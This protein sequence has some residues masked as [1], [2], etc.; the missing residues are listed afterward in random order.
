M[1]QRRPLTTALAIAGVSA[2]V[3]GCSA[4]TALLTSPAPGSVLARQ[5]F[6]S[7]PF[8][9]T[10]LAS[11]AV[12]T[13]PGGDPAKPLLLPP[14]YDQVVIASEPDYADTPD[15]NTQNE[16]GPRAGRYLYRPHEARANATVSVTDLETGIT[17]TIAQRADWEAL[18]PSV[19][20]PWGTLLVAE[21]TNAASHRSVGRG[22]LSWAFP[23]FRLSLVAGAGQCARG[24]AW[25]G[26]R[27]I[28]DHPHWRIT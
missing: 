13:V 10:P 5:A 23:G 27:T 18:D 17:K 14:G 11:S 2:A 21:E 15:I 8:Q 28:P 12:C 26:S 25:L 9:F 7:G 4:D 22:R 6:G 24:E 16:T 3:S 20:T 1:L 19:W